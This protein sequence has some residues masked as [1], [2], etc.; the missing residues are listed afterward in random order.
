MNFPNKIPSEICAESTKSNLGL[1]WRKYGR[2]CYLPD[3]QQLTNS[4]LQTATSKQWEYSVFEVKMSYQL[5]KNTRFQRRKPTFGGQKQHLCAVQASTLDEAKPWFA[6]CKHH[7]WMMQA[8]APH[9]PKP[10]GAPTQ[11]YLTYFRSV[12]FRQFI[13]TNKNSNDTPTTPSP[14]FPRRRSKQR[15]TSP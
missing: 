10:S 4:P 8:A 3:L 6:W 7:V 5:F 1:V 15:A 12:K 14:S 11:S 9:H 13:F 2:F